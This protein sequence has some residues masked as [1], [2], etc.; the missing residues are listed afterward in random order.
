MGQLGFSIARN[1]PNICTAHVKA[2]AD[3]IECPE[4]SFGF[5]MKAYLDTDITLVYAGSNM[6]KQRTTDRTWYWVEE[7]L[8][9]FDPD[10][11]KDDDEEEM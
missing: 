5:G 1:R 4:L 9:N 2:N 8:E 6:W 10:F 3:A 11:T 7:W